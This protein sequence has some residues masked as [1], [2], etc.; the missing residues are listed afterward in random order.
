MGK[1]EPS[2]LL[3]TSLA[4]QVVKRLPT[5]RETRVTKLLP[6]MMEHSMGGP[7]KHGN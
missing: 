5:A 3:R 7:L 4:A 6:A 2:A 1:R